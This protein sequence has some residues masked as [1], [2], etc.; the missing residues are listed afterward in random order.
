MNEK[1]YNRERIM[2]RMENMS[3][4][5]VKAMLLN[6]GLGWCISGMKLT[7]CTCMKVIKFSSEQNMYLCIDVV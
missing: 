5:K 7:I 3:P 1:W 4:M 2:Q 6:V